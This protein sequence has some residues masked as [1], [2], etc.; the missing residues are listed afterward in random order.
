MIVAAAG[1]ER[2]I[3]RTEGVPDPSYVI[4]FASRNRNHVESNA[5][6]GIC[7]PAG[8]EHS[9]RAD[10]LSLLAQVDGKFR[11]GE[12]S[13]AAAAYFNEREATAM[14]HDQVDFPA[15]VAEVSRDRLQAVADKESER[16]A[17]RLRA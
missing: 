4:G 3:L 13:R 11:P 10:N 5:V 9:R 6:A 14:Q 2:R 16:C 17:L 12:K 15:T 1:S 8:D 7:R